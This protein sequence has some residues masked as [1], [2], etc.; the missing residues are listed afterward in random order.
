MQSAASRW[1]RLP[2]EI[3]DM[4][5][6]NLIETYNGDPA[7]Q[8]T[9]LR[10]ISRRQMRRIENRFLNCWVPKLVVTLY[11]GSWI[12]I[13]YKYD[14][15]ASVY[16]NGTVSFETR[17]D[18]LPDSITGERLAALWHH[19]GFENRVAHLRLGEGVMNG[20][21]REGHIVNDTDLVGLKVAEDGTTITFNWKRT[22]GSLLRE[23]VVMCKIQN[24]MV[25]LHVIDSIHILEPPADTSQVSQR[26]QHLEREKQWPASPVEQRVELIRQLVLDIQMQKRVTVQKHRLLRYDPSGTARL[27]S[28]SP[29]SIYLHKQPIPPSAKLSRSRASSTCCSICSRQSG[30][31]IF[32]VASQ[33]ESVVMGLDG[34]QQLDAE[35][36]LS[37]Y[38][39]AFG[40]GCCRCQG[41]ENDSQWQQKR[42]NQWMKVGS[43]GKRERLFGETRVRWDPL[44]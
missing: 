16:E 13:D 9:T 6:E 34:W 26:I 24:D 20:G 1:H 14:A 17:K 8:W 39:E 33:E 11:S 18:S 19:Y 15:R 3:V 40:W 43:E 38:G 29:E 4:V 35:E 2:Q 7:Y 37:L 12:Q 41:R 21:I 10:H 32:E 44:G 25:R 27:G 28:L 5:L 31:S 23:E 42:K 30:P 36:L 22:M